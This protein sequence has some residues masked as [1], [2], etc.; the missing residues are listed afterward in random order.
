MVATL[1][2]CVEASATSDVV[3]VSWRLA[4]RGHGEVAIYRLASRSGWQEI[5]RVNSDDA[6]AIVYEDR[7]AEPGM[8]YGYRLG[9]VLGGK[10]ELVGEA[11]VDVP[12][13]QPFW[14][15]LPSPNP[16]AGRISVNYSLP[17]FAPATIRVV[18]VAGRIVFGRAVGTPGVGKQ[19]LSIGA[20]ERI[21]PG[22]YLVTRNQG[23][24]S[25]HVRFAVIR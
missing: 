20:R 2:E 1:A 23:T 7:S 10:V 25:A 6:G 16:S 17:L 3:R 15:G 13:A 12:A 14:L 4:K 21:P 11:W 8:R 9:I 22:I 18:D 19:V 5:A 24:R